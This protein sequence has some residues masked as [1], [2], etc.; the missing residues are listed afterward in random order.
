MKYSF[1]FVCQQGE[2]EI[3]SLLLAVS[4]K[5]YLRC[6]HELV[7]ALPQPEALWGKPS[8][9]TLRLLESSGVRLVPIGNPIGRDYPIGNKLACLGIETTADKIV[10]LDSDMLCL[11]E[12]HHA[13]RFELAFNAKPADLRTFGSE[14]GEWS[15]V[16]AAFG[17]DVPAVPVLATVSGEAMPPY[18]NAGMIAVRRDAGLGS[19]W[20]ECA[21]DRCG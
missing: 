11:R 12:F 14:P 4:L 2:L 21:R 17:L 5:R 20:V 18:F 16:Y 1:V 9:A 8:D 13:R 19:R 15:R 3:K 7:V 6:D 10:F